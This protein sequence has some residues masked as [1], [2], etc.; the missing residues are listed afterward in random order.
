MRIMVTGGGTGGHTSPTVAIIEELHQ[1]DPRLVLQ[2]VGCKGGLEDR[3]CKNL[4]I[5]FRSSPVEGWPRKRG[6]RTIWAGLKLGLGV[7]R[8]FFH[9][10][11]FRPQAVL[12]VGG[13][14]SVPLTWMAQRLGIPTILHEQN[15]RMGMANRLLAAKAQRLLLSYPDT[16]GD[17]PQDK[18]TVVGNPVRAA[19]SKPPER[20]AACNALNLDPAVPV[21]LIC[22][23]SQGA[24]T[25]NQATAE[26]LE[27]FKP[28][29][30][31]FI[32]MTGNHGIAQARAAAGSTALRVD[33][34]AFI[35]D[36]VTAC[37]ASTLIVGRAG[38]SLTAEI[39]ALA[40]PSILVPYP[41]AADNHQEQN[42]R[43]FE[44]AGAAVVL[45]D[46]D[47]TGERLVEVLRELLG[48]P[49]RLEAMGTAAAALA[50]PVAVEAIVEEIFSLVF[51]KAH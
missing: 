26:A 49:A 38:A 6:L 19:F 17:Y 36:M 16:L 18:A 22:G 2:W 21:V 42:A 44:Q 30:L 33:T 7:V 24:R 14:V 12:G 29:E 20:E 34:Y 9:L 46:G 47:C 45:L 31:Q 3:V 5:P 15:K 32:W 41:Y 23:G 11:R 48:D 10:K 8:A 51:E 37:A 28:Q 1:R 27:R 25:L 35:D 4:S 39:A 50:R 40:K 13:Y 43:A